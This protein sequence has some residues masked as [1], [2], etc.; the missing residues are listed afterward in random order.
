MMMMRVGAHQYIEEDL[1]K[2]K[3]NCFL[4]GRARSITQKG[5]LVL[6]HPF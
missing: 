2:K 5:F 1:D 4:E 3:K 6:F